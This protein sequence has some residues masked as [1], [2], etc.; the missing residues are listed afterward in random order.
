[1][2]LTR[3]LMSKSGLACIEL[4]KRLIKI[5]IGGRIPTVSDLSS[6]SGIPIGTTH[7]ALKTLIKNGAIQVISKGHMGS[8]LL[9]KDIKKLL[10]IIGVPYLFGTMPLPYTKRYEGLA[11]GLVSQMEK[12]YDI[13]VNIAYMRG[14]KTRI[15]M[16]TSGRYDFAIVS[17]VAAL[18]YIGK[19][20]DVCIVIDFG[21]YSYTSQHVIMFHNDKDTEIK[22]G[23]KIGIDRSSIDQVKLT[24]S[25]CEGKKVEYVEAQYSRIIE[26]V[27]DGTIDATV[28]NVDETIDKKLNVNC[29]P[30]NV[31][32]DNTTAVLLVD[33]NRQEIINL[34]NN[35]LDKDQVL[36]IQKQVLEGKIQPSY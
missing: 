5:P 9:D 28:M 27:I 13:P 8:Y 6:E 22:D 26:N 23:M 17:K 11:S 1:M 35:I 20:Q 14:S 25:A 10:S 29:V 21:P 16:L 18:E 3:E 4:A 15:E 2:D 36:A 32:V 31:G 34:I 30:L 7:N 19:H 33:S 12:S 24:E